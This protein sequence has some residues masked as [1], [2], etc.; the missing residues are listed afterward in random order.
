MLERSKE[1][2]VAHYAALVPGALAEIAPGEKN[3]VYKMM[4]LEVFAHRD[5]TLIADRG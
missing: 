1:A 3:K 4:G 2:L 5:G